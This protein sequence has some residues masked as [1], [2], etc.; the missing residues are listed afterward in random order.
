MNDQLGG[1]LTWKW[2]G[3][4]AIRES[5]LTHTILRLCALTEETTPQILHFVQRHTLK[6]Q[7]RRQAIAQLC[8]YVWMRCN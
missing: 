7:V 4:N 3:E 1:I 2:A 6:G 8:V 5:G